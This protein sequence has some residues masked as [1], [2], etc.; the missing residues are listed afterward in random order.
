M[1][2]TKIIRFP[3]SARRR[4]PPRARY[5]IRR[6]RW[7]HVPGF[8]PL[9]SATLVAAFL[10]LSGA[11]GATR[12]DVVYAVLLVAV[13]GFYFLHPALLRTRLGPLLV[14]AGQL[15]ALGVVAGFFGGIFWLIFSHP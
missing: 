9:L 1:S 5:V 11:A 8:G 14:V 6:R 3:R 7:V 12:H 10:Y 4:S 2:S 13:W 15:L